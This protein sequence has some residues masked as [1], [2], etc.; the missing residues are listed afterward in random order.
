MKKGQRGGSSLRFVNGSL[1]VKATVDSSSLEYVSLQC[2][3]HRCPR[4]RHH[5][6]RVAREWVIDRFGSAILVPCNQRVNNDKKKRD[7][8]V[9]NRPL[10]VPLTSLSRLLG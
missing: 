8:D 9:A 7:T 6:L 10:V 3:H 2:G 1:I 4:R 5:H